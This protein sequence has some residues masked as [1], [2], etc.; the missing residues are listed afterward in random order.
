MM[1]T[2]TDKAGAVLAETVTVNV[3]NDAPFQNPRNPYD[4]DNDGYVYPRDALIL[5]NRL[6]QKGSHILTP[7]TA[8]GEGGSGDVYYLDINGDGILSPLDALILINHLNQ[9]STP[10]VN[11]GKGNG[12][13][14]SSTGGTGAQSKVPDKVD[15]KVDNT[16]SQ[17]AEGEAPASFGACQPWLASSSMEQDRRDTIDSELELLVDELSRARLS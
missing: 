3:V 10:S 16:Q 17:L 14:G 5:V 4:V 9:R 12:T 8:S 7:I 15:P 1:V 6:N 2:V 13:G 11:N